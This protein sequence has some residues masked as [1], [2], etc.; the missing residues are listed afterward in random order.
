[1]EVGGLLKAVL[2]LLQPCLSPRPQPR[3]ASRSQT[4]SRHSRATRDPEMPRQARRQQNA[5][6][7]E[8][9]V[10]L[11]FFTAPAALLSSPGEWPCVGRERPRGS[12]SRLNLPGL[13]TGYYQ[14][15]SWGGWFWCRHPHFHPI[16][17][18]ILPSFREHIR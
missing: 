5:V 9:G 11:P 18:K 16:P 8:E 4:P 2:G 10:H 13:S 14:L 17:E 12:F 7:Q 3:P 15:S 6:K 1:M